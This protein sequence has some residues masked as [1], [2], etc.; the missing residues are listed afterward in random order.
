MSVQ[1]QRTLIPV[2]QMLCRATANDFVRNRSFR[3]YTISEAEVNAKMPF[4]SRVA[5]LRQKGKGSEP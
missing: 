3:K 1:M 5:L 4:I 2:Y